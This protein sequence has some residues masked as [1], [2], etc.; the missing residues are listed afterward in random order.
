MRPGLVSEEG[1]GEPRAVKWGL[2]RGRGTLLSPLERVGSCGAARCPK[3]GGG[4][5]RG[6]GATI[7][8]LGDL[9]PLSLS[10][11]KIDVVLPSLFEKPF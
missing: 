4:T 11:S 10:L 9:D 2:L 7:W 8:A 6:G 5:T 1:G 3:K